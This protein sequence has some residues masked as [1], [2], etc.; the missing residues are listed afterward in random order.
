MADQLQ[1]ESLQPLIVRQLQTVIKNHEL[2]HAY[3]FVGPTGSGKSQ[4]AKWLALRLFCFNLQNGE[5]DLTC[6][7][8]Q[9]IL[10]GNHPDVVVAKPEGR[11]I[12]VDEIRH[13]KDEFTKSAVEGN[14]KLF[15]I[16]DAEKM[17][18]NAANSLLKFIEEPGS[19]VYIL[20]L[21]T[22]KSAVLPTIRSRTQVIELQ[23]LPRAELEKGLAQNGVPRTERTVALGLTDSVSEV[24]EWRKDDWLKQAIT[25][26]SLWYRHTS[27]A[28][29][30][31]FVDVQTEIVKLATDRQKQQLILDLM[32]LIWRDT[33]LIANGITAEQDLHFVQEQELLSFT[34]NNYSV[35]TLL[36]ISQETLTSRHLLDQNMAF[37]NVAEQLTIKIVR[38]LS[39]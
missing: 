17:T 36:A 11:Q 20:M 24:M 15:I 5:P 39:A 13:L 33:L 14:R 21:T 16:H 29:M 3:L 18:N 22:N 4:L 9:R 7:E 27:K 31:G 37:Q 12:K 19:G 35:R 25:A 34:A 26:I 28:N 23:P 10:S 30:L 32:A 8:C 6:P 38:A 1:A 2:A